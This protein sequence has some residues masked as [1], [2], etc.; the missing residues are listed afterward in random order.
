VVDARDFFEGFVL[1]CMGNVAVWP[2]AGVPACELVSGIVVTKDGAS[3][4][5]EAAVGICAACDVEASV[6]CA[7]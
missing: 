1:A 4:C 2:E 3:G 6:Y 5:I 7:K